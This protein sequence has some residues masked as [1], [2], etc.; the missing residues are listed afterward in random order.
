MM[1]GDYGW[2][3]G[4]YSSRGTYGLFWSSTTYAYANSRNLSFVSTNVYPKNNGNK[5]YGFTLRRVAF[6]SSPQP[7]SFGYDVGRSLLGRW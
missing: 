2:G 7:S 4:N 3:S 5:L 6:Q 1:S